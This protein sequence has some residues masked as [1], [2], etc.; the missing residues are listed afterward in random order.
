M[1]VLVIGAHPDD[2]ALSCASTI[3]RHFLYK[4]EVYSIVVSNGEKIGNAE[5][6]KKEEDFTYTHIN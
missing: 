3:Y 2:I 6:R 5:A 4:D 1:K